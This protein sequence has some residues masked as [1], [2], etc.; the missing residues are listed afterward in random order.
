MQPGC[1]EASHYRNQRDQGKAYGDKKQQRIVQKL[2]IRWI[3]GGQLKARHTGIGKHQRHVGY[4][5]Q[6]Q[7]AGQPV[8]K[9]RG[10]RL[11]IA[12]D[13]PPKLY[14]AHSVATHASGQEVVGKLP[15]QVGTHKPAIGQ[16]VAPRP[17][18]NA[19]L[20]RAKRNT[21]QL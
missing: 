21:H 9:Y 4:Q 10:T 8:Y 16:V 19:P 20:E 18:N 5:A 15:H 12:P 11:A 14:H 6:R 17:Q 13:A 1:N 2:V 7:K 3:A